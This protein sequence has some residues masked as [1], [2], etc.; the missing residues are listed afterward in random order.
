MSLGSGPD[1]GRR[2]PHAAALAMHSPCPRLNTPA[3]ATAA[4]PPPA[5]LPFVQ[6]ML[7]AVVVTWAVW[8]W[9][10]WVYPAGRVALPRRPTGSPPDPL[11][12]AVLA[13]ILVC[14][15][16]AG[17]IVIGGKA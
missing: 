12:P 5:H 7:L 9:L 15:G 8:D 3:N 17:V 2:R 10:E 1:K 6:D 11:N 14:L 4:A 13:L 16:V